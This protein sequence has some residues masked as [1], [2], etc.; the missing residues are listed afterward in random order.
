MKVS[1]LRS[2]MKQFSRLHDEAG[3]TGKAQALSALSKT[4]AKHDKSTVA[5]VI[6]RVKKA[7]HL[8]K[9]TE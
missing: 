8:G 1:E 3:E 7:R 2:V 4:I 6:K 9:T 5:A